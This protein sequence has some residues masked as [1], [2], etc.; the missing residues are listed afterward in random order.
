VIGRAEVDKVAGDVAGVRA[1]IVRY[2]HVEGELKADEVAGTGSGVD[3][4]TI[5]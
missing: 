1:R 4:G 2:G 3:V 5:G